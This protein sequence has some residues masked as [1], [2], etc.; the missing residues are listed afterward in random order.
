[1]NASDFHIVLPEALL[2]LYAMAAL[3]GKYG[4]DRL[5]VGLVLRYAPLYRDLIAAR[6][7]AILVRKSG[8]RLRGA[9]VINMFPNTSHV[10]SIAL[11]EK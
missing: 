9:G 3:L 7:A 11:F 5:L 10:E 2:A 6:D 8:F 1:M 4:H